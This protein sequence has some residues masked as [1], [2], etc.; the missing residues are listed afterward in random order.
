MKQFA[1]EIRISNVDTRTIY[2]WYSE[3]FETEE[4]LE[5]ELDNLKQLE[6][7]FK[8]KFIFEIEWKGG[9]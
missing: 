6:Q 8:N 4:A 3:S 1:L 7:K 2:Q 9:N 5:N